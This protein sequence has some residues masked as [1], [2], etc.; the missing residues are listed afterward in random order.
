MIYKQID[1]TV[2]WINCKT[3]P[4]R[5]FF[6]VLLTAVAIKSQ[7]RFNPYLEVKYI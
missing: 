3:R 6:S 5:Q 1:N 4:N 2:F 7:Y